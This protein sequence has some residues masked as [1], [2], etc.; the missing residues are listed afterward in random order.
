MGVNPANVKAITIEN[1]AYQIV[2][3]ASISDDMK[4]TITAPTVKDIVSDYFKDTPILAKVAGCESEFRQVDS[5]GNI[6]R[7][8]ENHGDV[9]V[10]QINETY[11][12]DRA[13]KLGLNIYTLQGNMAYAKVLYNEFGTAPWMASSACWSK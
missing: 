10:M 2:Q 1:P 6:L 4:K 13:T 9:G 8:I 11:H 5:N 3:V 7:G 12:L